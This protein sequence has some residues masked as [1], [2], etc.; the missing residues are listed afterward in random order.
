MLL[1]NA[2]RPWKELIERHE[3]KPSRPGQHRS[4][5]LEH[6][7]DRTLPSTSALFGAPIASPTGNTMAAGI[8]T[9]DFKLDGT[10]DAVMDFNG[11]GKLDVVTWQSSGNHTFSVLLG[12]GDGTFNLAPGMPVALGANPIQAVVGDFNGDGKPDFALFEINSSD[13]LLETWLGDGTGGFTRAAG[14]PIDLGSFANFEFGFAAGDFNKDGNLDLAFVTPTSPS[15]SVVQIL[16]GDG[17][18]GF[19]EQPEL[20]VD[21]GTSIAVGDFNKDGSLDLAVAG[22]PGLDVLLGDGAGHFTKTTASPYAVDVVGGS[23]LSTRNLQV[24]DLTNDGNADLVMGGFDSNTRVASAQVLLGNGQGGFTVQPSFPIT[25]FGPMRLASALIVKDFNADGKLDLLAV[26]GA[27]TVSSEVFLGD[28]TGAF[29]DGGS[30]TAAGSVGTGNFNGD[31]F[32]DLAYAVGDANLHVT[33]HAAP[34]AG[35]SMKLIS[36]QNPSVAGQPVTFTATVTASDNS[37]P[38]GNVTITI[39][40]GTPQSVPLANGHVTF[41]PPLALA[42]HTVVVEYAAQGN[43]AGSAGGLIQVVR[44]AMTFTWSGA[45]Q[46]NLWSDG[47]NWVG[48]VA[49]VPGDHLVFPADAAQQSNV[50][51]YAVGSF[52]ASLLF[53]A[54]QSAHAGGKYVISGNGFTLGSGGITDRA[55]HSS[56]TISVPIT[57]AGPAGFITLQK[58]ADTLQLAGSVSNGPAAPTAGLVKSGAGDLVISSDS[59]LYTGTTLVTRGELDVENHFALGTGTAVVRAGAT[60]RLVLPYANAIGLGLGNP[61]VL[62]GTLATGSVGLLP[63]YWTGSIT[64]TGLAPSFAPGGSSDATSTL[65]VSGTIT[66]TPGLSMQGAGTLA[67]AGNNVYA[68]PT[69][70]R[71][72][73]VDVTNPAALGTHR[74]GASVS[75]GAMLALS[76]GINVGTNVA[77]APGARLGSLGGDNTW[78]GSVALTERASGAVEVDADQLTITGVVTQL[79]IRMPTAGLLKTGTGTLVLRGVNSIA[80]GVDV[81]DGVIDLKNPG[82]LGSSNIFVAA[83]GTLAL[84]LFAGERGRGFGFKQ[85]L[86]LSGT[87]FE[88]QGAL[89][90][91]GDNVTWSGAVQLNDLACIVTTGSNVLNVTGTLSGDTLV[92][93]GGGDVQLSGANTYSGATLVLGGDL[94]LLN[95]LALGNGIGEGVTVAAHAALRLFVRSVSAYQPLTL[96]DQSQLV[97]ETYNNWEYPVTYSGSVQ[98]VVNPGDT[99]RFSS[100]LT[101]TT[102]AR[103]VETGGGDLQINRGASGVYQQFATVLGPGPLD[104]NQIQVDA[105]SLNLAVPA[106]SPGSFA[107]AEKLGISLPAGFVPAVGQQFT[108]VRNLTSSAVI[109]TFDGLAEGSTFMVDGFTFEITYKG[110]DGGN[111]VVVMR[112][113]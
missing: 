19:R 113:A 75:T 22:G 46:D 80:G 44:R 41:T 5:S 93:A 2:Q 11:D 26:N 20:P 69:T 17:K 32:P 9:T 51:D 70:V 74:A 112:T 82:G 48:Y 37:T 21:I 109:G 79:G 73:I 13:L 35:T 30:V 72:G 78:S 108:I 85:S 60:L 47:A 14:S 104:V 15:F 12:N 99:L 40:N 49:P 1:L 88:N 28:G 52:F 29:T 33:L 39:D 65:I 89:E 42:S 10:S 61:L 98:I 84:D 96:L 83:G 58:S 106:R 45:S 91:L 24:V 34:I 7:E 53:T 111:D 27:N 107:L 95:A 103:L 8:V 87:G 63:F 36:S 59:T 43:L 102:G 67:L 71:T 6:L 18:G 76:G 23:D 94:D 92:V 97:A 110:G 54:G 101:G 62:A 66:G 55:D 31:G 57:L 100:Y 25:A 105:G 90:L 16:S 64:L 56:N 50:N 4:L 81:L 3:R 38:T 68:G 86:T 77:L